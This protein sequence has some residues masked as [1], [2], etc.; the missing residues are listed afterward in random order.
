MIAEIKP[1]IGEACSL[2]RAHVANVAL[3]LF[4]S[5]LIDKIPVG[6]QVN[7]TEGVHYS[8][9]G[10]R[11]TLLP[12]ALWSTMG[13]YRA[14]DREETLL[15]KGR[16]THP[17]YVEATFDTYEPTE[18][19][20]SVDKAQVHEEDLTITVEGAPNVPVAIYSEEGTIGVITVTGSHVMTVGADVPTGRYTLRP[21]PSVLD[22][23]WNLPQFSGEGA[24]MEVT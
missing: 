7:L 15:Y 22:P 14:G 19:V 5:E 13:H 20:I 11:V 12:H 4:Y 2:G 24:S 18:V 6:K 1:R 10:G 3:V 8:L 21:D 9:D 23:A 16:V 17:Q